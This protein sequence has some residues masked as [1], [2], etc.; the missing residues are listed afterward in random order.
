[1]RAILCLTILVLKCDSF[2]AQTREPQPS[3]VVL[4]SPEFEEARQAFEAYVAY[5]FRQGH[6][7]TYA[8]AVVVNQDIVYDHYINTDEKRTY[9]LASITKTFT[10]TAVMQLVDAGLISLDD[11]ITR[12]FPGL[13]RLHRA[14]LHSKPILIRH[15]LSHTSGLPDMRYYRD[16]EWLDQDETGLSMK[17][18]RQIY[19]A[20]MHYRYSNHG[21]MILGELVAQRSGKSLKEYYR[22]H[23]FEPMG[24]RDT[25]I[26]DRHSGAFGIWS[27]LRDM[28]QYAKIWLND[29]KNEHGQ[30][31]ISPESIARM[32]APPLY[33]PEG[34][35]LPYCGLG[36]RVRRAGDRV[37]TF[38]H[39]GGANGTMTW[40]QMFPNYK[41]AIIYL[42]N[43][44]EM[45]NEVM[46]RIPGMQER[47][48]DVATAV[49]NQHTA[50][51]AYEPS[52]PSMLVRSRMPGIYI[53]PL[54][55]N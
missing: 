48:G 46:Y 19:P 26:H 18:P 17:V 4:N 7:P 49:V 33:F 21:F 29:G 20:G 36:W 9:A 1:M 30:Q 54:T 39:V 52:L 37:N 25:W 31:V 2:Q 11:P 50:L 44:P 43:P 22:Q 14:S 13:R 34:Q 6:F 42:G 8:A 23:L 15:L 40:I 3:P 41:A 47:L 38:F 12:Y 27:S 35:N 51:Y 28:A 24:M 55:Q 16:P 5:G 10:A 45:K 32:H 53:S